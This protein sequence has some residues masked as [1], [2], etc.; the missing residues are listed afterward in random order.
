MDCSSDIT[1]DLCSECIN[2][3]VT[4]KTTDRKPH[5][6]NHGMFKV[7]RIIFHRDVGRIENGA[8]N[9][10]KSAHGIILLLKEGS[11]PG[12]VYCKATIS[13]PCWSCVEC[14]G[15]WKLGITSLLG[16]H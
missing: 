14:S 11:M 7:H 13:L 8:K 5:L 12:C 9:T 4:F 3:R 16:C 10:L 1:M 6:P 15:K 2:S